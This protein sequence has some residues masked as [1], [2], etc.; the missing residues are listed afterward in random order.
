MEKIGPGAFVGSTSSIGI[1]YLA[2]ISEEKRT[3][4]DHLAFF[5]LTISLGLILA[6]AEANP[7]SPPCILFTGNTL[8]LLE[9]DPNDL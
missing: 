9:T 3:S 7:P 8:T 1:D 4:L 5:D 2:T 6:T